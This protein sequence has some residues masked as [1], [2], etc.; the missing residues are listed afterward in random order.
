MRERLQKI[1][2]A[3]VLL[4][5]VLLL[6][7]C[8]SASSVTWQEQYDLGM[9]YLEEGDYEASIVAFATA[10][11]IDTKDIR[12]YTGLVQVYIHI[13]D[14]DTAAEVAG[15][16]T[17]ILRDSAQEQ[18]DGAADEFINTVLLL[19]TTC[20]E[21]N[22]CELAITVFSYALEMNPEL[23]DAY[24]GLAEVYAADNEEA[25]LENDDGV[26]DDDIYERY[27]FDPITFHI[28]G[29][30]NGYIISFITY[31]IRSDS[32]VRTYTYEYNDLGQVVNK[33]YAQIN[34]SGEYYCTYEF[35]YYESGNLYSTERAIYPTDSEEVLTGLYIY[36]EDGYPISSI[37]GV[38][39]YKIKDPSETRGTLRLNWDYDG[40]IELELEDGYELVNSLGDFYAQKIGG[41]PVLTS[42]LYLEDYTDI[43]FDDN[44]NVTEMYK[45]TDSVIYEKYF[46][47]L[48]VN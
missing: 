17:E 7:A 2:S 20:L 18:P 21:E 9:R 45:E 34:A 33:T 24:I 27:D 48:K 3:A 16:G 44:G 12:S 37:S 36:D 6:T 42:T 4:T 10:I 14:Y 43:V 19:G 13:G 1:K 28:D 25:T 23:E 8:A 31:T 39:S 46:T 26:A 38:E 15:L 40:Q 35:T 47:Y 5:A 11:E 41:A 32:S 22:L 29:V 30:Y